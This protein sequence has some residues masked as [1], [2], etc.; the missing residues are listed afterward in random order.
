MLR[1]GSRTI[2]V[3]KA[4][5]IAKIKENKAQHIE[6]YKEAV[7]AYKKEA[8]EQLEKQIKEVSEGSIKVTLNLVSPV[9]NTENYDKIISMFEWEVADE[10]ELT[11]DEFLEYVENENDFAEHASIS[12]AM[13]K[14]K[15]L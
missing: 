10:V 12:N 14:S 3:K 4:D 13:Y 2:K 5:L 8:L 15:W 1:R 11:Q 7:I 6:D 9:D